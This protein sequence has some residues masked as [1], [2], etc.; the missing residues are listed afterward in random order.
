M[1]LLAYVAVFL[2]LISAS[3]LHWHRWTIQTLPVLALC[4]GYALQTGV[5]RFRLP[6]LV[7]IVI[8]GLSSVQLTCQLLLWD[9]QQS[10]TSPQVL[11][12]EWMM[13][14]LPVGTSVVEEWYGPPLGGTGIR[15]RLQVSLSEQPLTSY[16]RG[17]SPL[18][19][20]HQRYLY[21]PAVIFAGARPIRGAGGFLQGVVW[22]KPAAA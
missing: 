3:A 5:R 8:L 14:N 11:G 18:R 12:R 20:R 6:H 19:R 9:L 15:S 10:Q 21:D 2:V 4:G 13:D 22:E 7:P 1:P 17:G 16:A